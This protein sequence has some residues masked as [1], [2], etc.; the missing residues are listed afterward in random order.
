MSRIR[1]IHFPVMS[2][3]LAMC[4]VSGKPVDLQMGSRGFGMGGAFAAISDDAS[5]TY[6]NPAGLAQLGSLT[7]SETNWILQDVSDVNVNYF[8]GAVPLS[9]VGTVSGGWL[10]QHANLEQGEPGTAQHAQ[11]DWYEHAFSIAAGREL[12]KKLWIFENTSLGFSLDRYVLNSGELNGAGTGFDLGFLTKLPHGLRLGFVMRS[13]GADMMGDKIDP[14]YRLGLGYIWLHGDRDRLT[15]AFDLA[16][17]ENIEYQNTTE[18]VE[19]NYRGFIGAE[20][21][22]HQ[23]D[24]TAAIRAGTNSTFLNS[25]DI[26]ALTTGA[27]IGYRGFGF[28]YAFQYNSTEALS[29]GQSHRVTIEVKL[30]E[31]MAKDSDKSAAKK[32]KEKSHGDNAGNAGISS[33]SEKVDLEFKTGTDSE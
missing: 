32:E 10:M 33:E 31:F 2:G 6:W 26:L 16:T 21:M 9:E 24:W 28:Q 1:N 8:T 25:R 22:Y 18:G 12:W 7:I 4:A 15:A 17:K 23:E 29:L 3:L 13:L 14:E 5:A 30:G 19:R 27:G 11:S 20:Y